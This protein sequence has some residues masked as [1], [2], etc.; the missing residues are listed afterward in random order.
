MQSSSAIPPILL[1]LLSTMRLYST[2]LD[3][4][5]KLLGDI[6][7][8]HHERERILKKIEEQEKKKHKADEEQRIKR[9]E[10]RALKRKK[11]TKRKEAVREKQVEHW[12]NNPQSSFEALS[13]IKN[14]VMNL[15]Q[16]P[17]ASAEN[18]NFDQVWDNTDIAD[19]MSEL[20]RHEKNDLYDEYDPKFS[21][22]K[23]LIAQNFET[24]SALA[25]KSQHNKK[26]RKELPEI[27]KQEL[28]TLVTKLE[29]QMKTSTI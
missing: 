3:Q 18:A 25:R 24:I 19:F 23:D 14:L 12:I 27:V 8:E 13:D 16:S 28:E 9:K 20:L 2:P 5:A 17:F 11:R 7:K 26:S 15:I 10:E 1:F 29:E 21:S 22:L 4:F 6:A